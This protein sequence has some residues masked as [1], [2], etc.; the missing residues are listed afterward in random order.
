L[1]KAHCLFH[2]CPS[3]QVRSAFLSLF[4][5]VVSWFSQHHLSLPLLFF[6]AFLVI[7]SFHFSF[8]LFLFVFSPLLFSCFHRLEGNK[9]EKK[10][11]AKD[12][13]KTEAKENKEEAIKDPFAEEEAV[14]DPFADNAS[15]DTE[16]ETQE[17]KARQA[18][19]D[20]IAAEKV[21]V[22]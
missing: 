2:L 16:D 8:L 3:R 20:K 5:F 21:C 14:A 12:S 13:K 1:E 10:T 4:G 6:I 18:K 11:E 19:I 22:Q 7:S 15:A 17:E 9:S